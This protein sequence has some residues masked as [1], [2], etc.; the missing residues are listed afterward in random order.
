LRRQGIIGWVMICMLGVGVAPAPAQ[1]ATGTQ[2]P[3][4]DAST[5]ETDAQRQLRIIRTALLQGQTEESRMDAAVELFPRTDSASRELLMQSLIAKDNPLTRQAICRALI[6]S[7][8]LAEMVSKPEEFLKP[9]VGILS[10]TDI[11][12]ARLAGEALLIYSFDRVYASLSK[13]AV[14]ASLDPRTRLNVIFA[15]K[16]WP[17]KEAIAAIHAL[18]KDSDKTVAAAAD[19]ALQEIF[20]LPEGTRSATLDGKVQDYQNRRPTEFVRDL[21]TVLRDRVA[22]QQEQLRMVGADRDIWKTKYLAMQDKEYAAADDAGKPAMLVTKLTSELAAERLWALGKVSTYAAMAS[23]ELRTAVLS[24]VLDPDRDVR[25]ATAKVLANK[26]ALDPAEKLLAQL[27]VEKDSEVALALFQALGE[28]CSFAFT[29]GSPIK[30]PSSVRMD[31]LR[32]AASF[33]A[34]KESDRVYPGAEVI[35]KVLEINGIETPV[36]QS[37]LRMILNRY[38]AMEGQ[39]GP[40]RGQLLM[41]MAKLCGKTALRDVATMLYQPALLAGLS[42][43]A[44]ATVR[45]AAVVGMAN[46]GKPQAYAAF[47]DRK[48]GDDPSP[49]VRKIVIGLA[50]EVGDEEELA[51]LS[52]RLAINGEAEAAWS[53]MASIL[54]RQGAVVIL[55]WIEK[56]KANAGNMSRVTELMGIVEGRL[57]GEKNA[58]SLLAVRMELLGRYLSVGDIARAVGVFSRRLIEQKDLKSDDPLIVLVQTYLNSGTVTKETKAAL[59]NALGAIAVPTGT[60]W[61]RWAEQLK[62]WQKEYLPPVP[63][64][65]ATKPGSEVLSVPAPASGAGTSSA[66]PNS[67][68]KSN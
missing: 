45:E 23:A 16:L 68:S 15:L 24:L 10:S 11:S 52:D 36:A 61:P 13:M 31:T 12:E 56:L 1:E 17:E 18:R 4:S 6:K 20:G 64:P 63:T 2:L 30:L 29:P 43:A 53:A 58:V 14:D 5:V 9:I 33:L 8:G 67:P 65:A 21:M 7:R 19:K 48:L 44:D 41:V 47:R 51:W 66:N 39:T 57:Q 37:Y 55:G 62:A 28:A 22:R 32:L 3:K 38:Q 35:R 42:D 46:I 60:V 49:A 59:I 26:S 50:G 54:Q 40:L 27:Q 25:L 34:E